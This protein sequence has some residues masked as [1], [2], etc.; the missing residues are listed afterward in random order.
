MKDNLQHD[1][2]A[3]SS[4]RPVPNNNFVKVELM[5]LTKQSRYTLIVVAGIVVAFAAGILGGKV[6]GD[7]KSGSGGG[8]GLDISQASWIDHLKSAG[9]VRVGCADSPPTI[10]VGTNGKCTGTDLIPIQNFADELGIK[11]V[12]VATTWQNIVAGLQSNKY[13]IAADLDQTVERGLAIQFTE[14]SWSYPGVFLVER[15]GGLTSVDKIKGSSKPIATAQGTAL[16]AALQ[17]AK[18]PELRVD[19]YENATA[20]LHAG[21]ASSVFTDLGTAETTVAKDS[22]LGIVVP[23]PAIFVHY[24]AYGVPTS[25]DPRSLQVLN[26]AITTSVASG[27]VDRANAAAGFKPQNQL[28]ES[29]IG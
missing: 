15:S 18:L 26:I 25:I 12:T 10:V 3:P 29:Q 9:E 16:D 7:G 19:T 28:G 21:R 13:D 24:V 14:P 4:T 17:A 11:M 20:A 23:K 27:E 1:D 2:G 8:G 6:G 5:A 22:S